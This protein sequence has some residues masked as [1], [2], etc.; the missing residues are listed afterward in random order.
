MIFQ[1][2]LPEENDRKGLDHRAVS[3]VE[4]ILVPRSSVS[5]GHVV[6]ETEV[7][8]FRRKEKKRGALGTRMGR[9]SIM[10]KYFG[11]K[12]RKD[13]MA[14][15]VC[16]EQTTAE[17]GSEETMDAEHT[18]IPNEIS[19]ARLIITKILNENFKSYAGIQE[20]GPF[21]KVSF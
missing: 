6:G 3:L 17:Q 10:G 14:D 4:T 8:G 18:N 19:T 20:L 9:T 11:A 7:S 21:H 12:T 5:F 15:V 13:K 1:R 2:P 16:N